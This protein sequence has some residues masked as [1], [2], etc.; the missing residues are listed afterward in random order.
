MSVKGSGHVQSGVK[1][2]M[3]LQA[4]RAELERLQLHP[5]NL[6]VSVKDGQR[7]AFGGSLLRYWSLPP[8]VD[9]DWL[10]AELR[11]L[12]DA[13][14][15]EAVMTSLVTAHDKTAKT[16]EAT[17]CRTPLRLFDSRTEES[18]GSAES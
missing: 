4:I 18:S 6:S 11:G 17:D 13:T 9:G 5:V 15:V 16:M 12:P 3:V 2:V 14:G 10:L 7:F 8:N 1:S